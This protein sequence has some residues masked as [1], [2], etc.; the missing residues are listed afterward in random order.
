MSVPD[1]TRLDPDDLRAH[2]AARAAARHGLSAADVAAIE[3]TIRAGQGPGCV[4]VQTQAMR[5]HRRRQ[6]ILPV[7]RRLYAVRH[8]G[9]WLPVVYDPGAG[10]VVTFLPERALEPFRRWPALQEGRS[11]S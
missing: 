6:Y 8:G 4:L 5:M 10:A 2:A 9:R 1:D 3:A 11:A 7:P